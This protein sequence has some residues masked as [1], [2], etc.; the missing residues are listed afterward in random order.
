VCGRILRP[1]TPYLLIIEKIPADH[2]G[3][4]NKNMS[5]SHDIQDLGA[6]FVQGLTATLGYKGRQM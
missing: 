2:Q 5:V 4:G 6:A 3:D 1:H